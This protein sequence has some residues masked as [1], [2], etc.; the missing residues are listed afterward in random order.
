[1][2]TVLATLAAWLGIG[3]PG[4]RPLLD[5]LAGGLCLVLV[6][7]IAAKPLGL[8]L[9]GYTTL[10]AVG[11]RW[12]AAISPLQVGPN[13]GRRVRAHRVLFE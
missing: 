8:H 12:V 6:A 3:M 4:R 5:R 9:Q 11:D 10:A 7:Q 13:P 1:M 2:A